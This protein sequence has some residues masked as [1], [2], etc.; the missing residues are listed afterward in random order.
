M[1][2]NNLFTVIYP[3]DGNKE[4]AERIASAI[5]STIGVA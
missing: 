5:D 4:I 2:K 1:I 3:R